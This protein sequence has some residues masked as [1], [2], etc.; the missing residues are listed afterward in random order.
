MKWPQRRVT[1]NKIT[2]VLVYT[3]SLLHNQGLSW[4]K[5]TGG[6]QKLDYQKAPEITLFINAKNCKRKRETK[7]KIKA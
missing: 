1:T 2:S 4:L 3:V 5:I 7:R 6:Q